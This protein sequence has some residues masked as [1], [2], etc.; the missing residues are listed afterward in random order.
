MSFGS[1]INNVVGEADDDATVDDDDA[2][3]DADEISI[4]GG[5]ISGGINESS[6]EFAVL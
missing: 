6:S 4:G 2:D 3:D 1:C 5:S